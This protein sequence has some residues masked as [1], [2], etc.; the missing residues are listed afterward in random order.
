LNPNVRAM[1]RGRSLTEV[2]L[3]LQLVD[4]FPDSQDAVNLLFNAVFQP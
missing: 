2:R 4:H 3:D 1:I